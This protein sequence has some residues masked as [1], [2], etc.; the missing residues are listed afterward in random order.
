MKTAFFLINLVVGVLCLLVGVS[1]FENL[2]NNLGGAI[3]GGVAILMAAAFLW[4]AEQ[5]S[6]DAP[7]A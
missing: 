1:N 6:D 7:W 4:L 2:G 5:T 3:A